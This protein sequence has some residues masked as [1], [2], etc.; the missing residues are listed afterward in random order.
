MGTMVG[1][2]GSI[3][4][5]GTRAYGGRGRWS[6]VRIETEGPVY[7]GRVYVPETKR[8]LSDVLSDDRPFISLTEVSINDSEI[9]EP[10]V[11]VNKHY[12]RTVRILHEGDAEVMPASSGTR[13]GG[14]L[15]VCGSA[16]SRA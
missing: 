13:P 5:A 1:V 10:F 14:R 9:I 16:P 12:I 6:T 3:A 8:R 4:A 2:T 7:V 15:P 11:A